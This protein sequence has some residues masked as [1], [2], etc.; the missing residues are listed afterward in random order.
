MN[1]RVNLEDELPKDSRDA[2]HKENKEVINVS[3]VSAFSTRRQVITSFTFH[4][5][6]VGVATRTTQTNCCSRSCHHRPGRRQKKTK[7]DEEGTA[8]K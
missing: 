8:R 6:T 4:L 3:F 2:D 5:T 7:F 1:S